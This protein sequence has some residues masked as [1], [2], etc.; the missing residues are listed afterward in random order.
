MNFVTRTLIILLFFL[1][2]STW[3]Q[4]LDEIYV[5]E[6]KKFYPSKSL[7]KGFHASIFHFEDF[8]NE[9]IEK[10]IHFNEQCLTKLSKVDANIDSIDA[11][12]LRTQILSEIDQWKK[13]SV[14]NSS[15][16][17]YTRLISRTMDEILK[18]DFLIASEKTN[19]TCQRLKDIIEMSNAAKNNLKIV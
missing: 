9:N 14:Q 13:L 11:R 5:N 15:L 1:K 4:S 10:W 16:T 8:S 3:S 7:S 2:T 19:L 18:A 6:W 12:L 17:L